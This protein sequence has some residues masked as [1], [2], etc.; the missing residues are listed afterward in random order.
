MG[1][2]LR[3]F[4]ALAEGLNSVPSFHIVWLVSPVTPVPGDSDSLF[5]TP[6]A[7]AVTCAPYPHRD[8]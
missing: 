8:T 2:Q 4:S 6:Q 7:S 3:T 1:P 5:W